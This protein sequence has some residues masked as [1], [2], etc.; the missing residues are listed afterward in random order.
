M[1]CV[2]IVL[3][4]IYLYDFSMM[5]NY[6]HYIDSIDCSV[7]LSYTRIHIY[8]AVLKAYLSIIPY[9]THTHTR[10]G[11]S[12]RRYP[13]IILWGCACVSNICYAERPQLTTF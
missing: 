10:L 7:F 1:Y 12:E 11:R 9:I 8:G 5:H 2:L 6:L 4:H 3:F 13:S